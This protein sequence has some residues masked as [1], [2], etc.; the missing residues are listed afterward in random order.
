VQSKISH[1]GGTV[2]KLTRT[3]PDNARLIEELYLAIFSRFPSDEE[4]QVALKHFAA[5]PQRRQAAEDLA[6]SMLNSLEF[7][8]NH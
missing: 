5:S 2:A 6:W 1:D 3:T 8:F 7:V 4:K